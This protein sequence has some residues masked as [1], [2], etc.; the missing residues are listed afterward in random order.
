ME[1]ISVL[2]NYIHLS[3]NPNFQSQKIGQIDEDSTNVYGSI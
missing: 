2:N 1:L 3:M